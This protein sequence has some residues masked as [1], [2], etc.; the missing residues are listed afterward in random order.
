MFSH[1][2]ILQDIFFSVIDDDSVVCKVWQFYN[3]DGVG[4]ALDLGFPGVLQR[5]GKSS[6][7]FPI[8]Y[9]S[10]CSL[11]V[12]HMGHFAVLDQKSKFKSQGISWGSIG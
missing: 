4:R 10:F 7:S 2:V 12:C 8:S 9:V 6:S 1:Q 11:H 5:E 3:G